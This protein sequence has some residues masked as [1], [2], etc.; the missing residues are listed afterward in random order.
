VIRVRALTLPKISRSEA[1]AHLSRVQCRTDRSAATCQHSPHDSAPFTAHTSARHPRGCR[2]PL[3]DLSLVPHSVV[4]DPRSGRGRRRVAMHQ[5]R[6]ALGYYAA[7]STCQ[8]RF[9]ACRA[10]TP[11]WDAGRQRCIHLGRWGWYSQT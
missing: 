9:M 2:P 5:M 8:L 10:R 4:A 3:G 1:A 6:P 7:G 11:R